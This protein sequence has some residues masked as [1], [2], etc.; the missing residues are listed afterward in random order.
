MG[1]PSSSY[2]QVSAITRKYFMPKLYDNIFL[3][4]PL[5]N[6][7]KRKGWQKEIDGGEQIVIPLEYAE[8]GY[9]AWF[10]GMETLA[11]G[12]TDT[13]TAVYL[14]WKQ[15]FA[16]IVISKLDELKNK[17]TSQVVDL[18]KGKVKNAEKTLKKTLSTGL[19][20][21]GTDAKSIIGLRVW[22]NADETIGGI[23]QSTSSFFQ[24]QEDTTTTVLTL[25]A[26][27]TMFSDCSED[28]DQPTVIMA[29]KANYNRVFALLQ[30]QQRFIDVEEA[31]AGFTSLMFNS[32][33]ILADSNCPSGYMF[34][35]NENY[36]HLIFHKDENMV[37][38]DFEEPINQ[39]GKV[40]KIFGMC[41]FGCSNNR[42]QGDFT[43]IAA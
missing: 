10:Q 27:Q 38:T 2:T 25:S 15:V 18:V 36:L 11:L 3:G 21:A 42:F 40:A 23:S 30:P 4:N 20:S 43:S 12:D 29:T 33:P 6:R 1:V 35:L 14:D 41:G 7:A 17:G 22:V 9:A 31:K 24:A 8:N 34:F 39:H 28:N 37:M 5:P 26:M 13:F 16:P 32:V 19:Y